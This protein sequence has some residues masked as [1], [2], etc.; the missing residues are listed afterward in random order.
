MRVNEE[1]AACRF[2]TTKGSRYVRQGSVTNHGSRCF[3]RAGTF[4]DGV[5]GMSDLDKA[6]EASRAEFERLVKDIAGD[7]TRS[8][9][10]LADYENCAT[11]DMWLGWV[12]HLGN[13]RSALN[14]MGYYRDDSIFTALNLTDEQ[15]AVINDLRLLGPSEVT[16]EDLIATAGSL[17]V[18][19]W[20]LG[21]AR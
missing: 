11:Q 5:I 15:F 9:C 16:L 4:S 21:R 3:R 19:E 17:L 6:I 12:W 7:L 1:L 18:H 2:F 13:E 14:E 10:G 20:K 8:D